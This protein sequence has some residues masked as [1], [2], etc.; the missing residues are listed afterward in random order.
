MAHAKEFPTLHVYYVVI[1]TMHR[2]LAALKD[3]VG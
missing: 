1:L 2:M 3:L